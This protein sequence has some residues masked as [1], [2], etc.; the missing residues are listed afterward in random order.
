MTRMRSLPSNYPRPARYT[1]SVSVHECVCVCVCGWQPDRGVRLPPWLRKSRGWRRN[2]PR[3]WGPVKRPDALGFAGELARVI[4]PRNR[5][6]VRSLLHS[7]LP[8]R[9]SHELPPFCTFRRGDT[10]SG[11]RLLS[12][13]SRRGIY[14]WIFTQLHGRCLGV[15]QKNRHSWY[16]CARFY[17]YIVGS[18]GRLCPLLTHGCRIVWAHYGICMRVDRSYRVE[19]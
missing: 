13:P 11:K 9:L 1:P 6:N 15:L 8:P 16:S 18:R 7:N 10:L 3:K 12:I 14:V 17:V 4:A 5:T 2:V 19:K